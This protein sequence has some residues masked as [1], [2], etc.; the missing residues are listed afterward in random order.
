MQVETY[1]LTEVVAQ[2]VEQSEE[3]KQLIASMGLSGQEQFYAQP[4][5]PACPYRKLTA[6]EHIVYRAILSQETPI[7]KYSDGPI[8]LRVLQIGAHAVETLG[9]DLVVFHPANADVKDPLLLGKVKIS[10]YEFHYYLLARWG[11]ELEEF[12]VLAERAKKII[13]AQ[14]KASYLKAKHEL[15]AVGVQ[16]DS[17]AEEIVLTGRQKT[18]SFH[19]Y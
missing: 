11:E 3:C 18:L 4:D 8:P 1:E 14:L 13:A 16:L 5:K 17:L 7:G 9:C 2:T 6:Q 15:E 10:S 19:F 12:S